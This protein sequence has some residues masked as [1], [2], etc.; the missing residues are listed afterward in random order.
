VVLV[1]VAVARVVVA[2]VVVEV[3]DPHQVKPNKAGGSKPMTDVIQELTF[4][5]GVPKHYDDDEP[6]FN[7]SMNRPGYK[8]PANLPE[9]GT[10]GYDM[11]YYT[12]KGP[13]L[14]KVQALATFELFCRNAEKE[15]IHLEHNILETEL[16]EDKTGDVFKGL[17]SPAGKGIFK[18]QYRGKYAGKYFFNVW[19]KGKLE[20][21]PIFPGKGI[22]F[23]CTGGEI[24]VKRN[25]YFSASG[26]GL[27][28]G[29]TGRSYSFNIEVK[30]DDNQYLD[31]DI[32]KMQ[33]QI[34]QG[35][36]KQAAS[37][38][39]L[40]VGKYKATFTPFGPGE[41]VISLTYGAEPVIQTTV[42]YGASIDP[43]K[44]EI[45]SPPN[46]V[47]VGQQHTFT[48]QAKADNET[49]LT[50]GGEKFDVAVSGPAGGITGLVVR[51][52]LNGKYVVRFT[53]V[54][55][56]SYKFFVSL[57]G[58]DIKGSPLNMEAR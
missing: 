3:P 14:V 32:Y 24:I 30:D 36:K 57:R 1:V 50:Q 41:M 26:F 40:N 25:M 35:L 51:D 49:D 8:A 45:V 6:E 11:V 48:I 17:I 42:N 31:C 55:A 27:L 29:S 9:G 46:H 39:R 56:G 7:P 28:G 2:V 37:I 10:Q 34:T 54:K 23:E 16:I 13:T 15:L 33:V 5:I 38:D 20:K 58:A 21:K 43:F 47:L 44:T 22:E 18:L 12:I 4:A 53:M 52:E 19:V